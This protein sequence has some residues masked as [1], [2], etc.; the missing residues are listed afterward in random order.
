MIWIKPSGLEF[1]T[2]DSPETIKYLKSLGFVEKGAKKP[3][4]TKPK[5]QKSKD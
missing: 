2:N 3:G 1:E 4:S 5:K